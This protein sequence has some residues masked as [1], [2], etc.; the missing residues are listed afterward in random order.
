MVSD[1][2]G[3]N[4]P[5][6]AVSV[7][8]HVREG[9]RRPALGAAARRRP[10]RAVVR[11]QRRRP[12][13][14]S[15]RIMDEEGVRLPGPRQD[16]EAAG[17][18]QPRGDRR[19]VRRRSWSPAATSAWSCRSSTCR[20]C[21][22]ARST[23]AREHAKPVIVATQMLESM[24][25]ASRPTRAEASDV[26]NAVLD[27]ADAL[28]LSG[29][30]SRRAATRSTSCGTMARIIDAGRGRGARPAA[31]ARCD[32]ND[33]RPAPSAGPRSTSARSSAPVPRRVHR[34]RAL[35]AAVARH[36]SPIPLLA[37]TPE[38][39]EYAAS[40]PCA[41]ASRRS[42][43]PRSRTPTTWSAWS[44]AA[45]RHR[46]VQ[47]R[48]ADRHRRRRPPGHPGLDQRPAGPPDGQQ[49]P[50]RNLTR[51]LFASKALRLSAVAAASARPV[52]SA[53]ISPA[54]ARFRSV[55]RR[56]HDDTPYG[57]AK[58]R[59]NAG[60]PRCSVQTPVNR[61]HVERVAGSV[62][63]AAG[64]GVEDAPGDELLGEL[65]RATRRR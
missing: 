21:R 3:I 2:K 13:A 42:W 49:R 53:P 8:A 47:G 27:G 36:R 28:M 11:A 7:P 9:H 22:S 30:T 43:S 31:R 16:R 54:F 48:R 40:S 19:G 64:L 23:L 4:L 25:G 20:W 35:G 24:V 60:E 6:V 61:W 17:G 63:G 29:E 15:T 5:G 58:S 26:A 59:A 52:P 38:R 14:T 62:Q 44:T 41:G 39:R 50:Q 55:H 37:F 65:A 32:R 45:P 56:L 12:R 10:D 51:R 46:P 33:Q 18:R 34:D 1:H 57:L